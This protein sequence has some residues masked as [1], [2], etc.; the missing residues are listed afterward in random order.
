MLSDLFRVLRDALIDHIR[1]VSRAAATASLDTVVVY[2]NSRTLTSVEFDNSAITML[3][4]GLEEDRK[5]L[6]PDPYRRTLADGTTVVVKP[7]VALNVCVLFVSRFGS[8]LETLKYLDY[9]V[10]FFQ[11]YKL[12]DRTTVP[13]LEGTKIEKLVCE[14]VTIPVLDN[15]HVWGMLN[16]AYQPSLLYRIRVVVFHDADGVPAAAPG[17]PTTEI[18]Q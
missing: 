17:S 15:N 16:T 8:Y 7:A 11:K 12:I 13:A 2:A 10:Q 6:P 9:V 14:L 3:L 4:V 5:V 18:S 1:L